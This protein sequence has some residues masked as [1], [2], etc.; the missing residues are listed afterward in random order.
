MP[1]R[2]AMSLSRGILLLF[3]VALIAL[4]IATVTVSGVFNVMSSAVEAA[5]WKG[6]VRA[7]TKA[8]RK[9]VRKQVTRT[10]QRIAKR[11]SVTSARNVASIA[12]EALPVVG[13]GVI[14]AGTAWEINEACQTMQ[15]LD[16][17]DRSFNT[18]TTIDTGKVCGIEVPDRAAVWRTI[19]DSPGTAWAA[20]TKHL[21]EMPDFSE[22]YAMVVST[23]TGLG[24]SI[25]T[26]DPAPKAAR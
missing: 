9:I 7:R 2:W 26:C 3:M 23:V 16:Q 12:G 25:L 6:T 11:V 18:D 15:D 8:R 10:S 14:V 24:C 5:G 20:A 17:L 4:N 19:R 21:P 13:V 22:S 1:V